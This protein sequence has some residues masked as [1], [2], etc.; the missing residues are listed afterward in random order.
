M[1]VGM[2]NLLFISLLSPLLYCNY[3]VAI[4]LSK[5][6]S[7]STQPIP[8][9]RVS[10]KY[11]KGAAQSR[12][13]GW[14]QFSFII[15]KDGS[16]SNVINTES[17]GSKDLTSAAKKAILKW[18]YEPA[19][20]NGKPVQQC[21]NSVQM[22]FRMSKNGTKTVTR[23]FKALYTKTNN[24][25]EQKDYVKVE[26][27]LASFSKIKYMHMSENNFLQLLHAQYAKVKGDEALQLSHLYKV[28]FSSKGEDSEQTLSVLEQRFILEVKLNRLKQAYKTFKA[29][30]KTPSA[31]PYLERYQ[32]IIKQVDEYINSEKD[33]MVNADIRSN[34]YW[35]YAL[36]RNE[37]TLTN[38]DGKLSKMDIRCANKRHVYSI[39]NNN[40]W[41]IPESWQQC[42]V[43][44]FGDDDTTFNLVEHPFKT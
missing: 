13:E 12:R 39:E 3:A 28:R 33:F 38:I 36:A 32:T 43:F 23:R 7:T 8:K 42:N 29:I 25:L 30:E 11:P 1:D 14:A 44:I 27:Y 6:L 2:K 19:M 16:V 24:A 5:H 10:P 37:F 17:S 34:N 9:I 20:E 21:V 4:E 41:T 40:T 35:H 22:D 18:Q 26:E 31:K 15:E